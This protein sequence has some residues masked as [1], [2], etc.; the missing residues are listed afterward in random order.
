MKLFSDAKDEGATILYNS[1]WIVALTYTAEQ[2][3]VFGRNKPK[4]D[5]QNNIIEG[6]N[7]RDT[8]TVTDENG[9]KTTI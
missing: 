9:T 4:V 3:G 5:D 8:E 2:N 6:A 7:M 1:H